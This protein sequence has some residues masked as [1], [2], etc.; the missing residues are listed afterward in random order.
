MILRAAAVIAWFI[1]L[2]WYSTHWLSSNVRMMCKDTADMRWAC[3]RLLDKRRTQ[4]SLSYK[5]L[6]GSVALSAP[7]LKSILYS[8]LSLFYARFHYCSCQLLL[9]MNILC[10]NIRQSM[11]EDLFIGIR[12]PMLIF[13][14]N[15]FAATSCVY[16]V[17][18]R[19]AMYSL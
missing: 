7:S 2:K 3:V 18:L 11:I 16:N 4:S 1:D 8:A 9:S 15:L 13:Y 12:V 19:S 17:P 10:M 5:C 6:N 14:N